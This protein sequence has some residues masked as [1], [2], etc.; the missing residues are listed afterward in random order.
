MTP[1]EES[2]LYR[3]DY[4]AWCKYVAPRWR[5]MLIAAKTKDEKRALWDAASEQLRAE[6]HALRNTTL[7]IA[8]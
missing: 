2:H 1:A 7:R 6:L 5:D 8:A 4:E 3:T